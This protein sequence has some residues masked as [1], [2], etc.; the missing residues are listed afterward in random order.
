M[1]ISLRKKIT[2]AA[3]LDSLMA[4]ALLGSML[5][6][7]VMFNQVNHNRKIAKKLAAE[8]ITYARIYAKYMNDNYSTLRN[9]AQSGTNVV[10]SPSSISGKWSTDLA[11]SNL[12]RQ[13]PCVSIVA[14]KK[15]GY[16]ESILY[17]AGGNTTFSN[18]EA[19]ILRQ[20]LV[21]LGGA[22]G[23]FANGI[24]RGN[25]GWSIDRASDFLATSNQCGNGELANNSLAINMDLLPEWNRET[26][27]STAI[28]KEI[29]GGGSHDGIRKMP[30]HLLNANTSKSDVTL[31]SGNG[32]IVD[33]HDEKNPIK[34]KMG[35]AEGT[36]TATIGLYSNNQN[37]NTKTLADTLEPIQTGVAGDSCDIQEVGKIIADRGNSVTA[38]YL[39]RS[40]LVCSQNS[41]MCASVNLS[42]TCYLPTEANRIIFANSTKGIQSSSG[43]FVCPKET[44]FASSAITSSGP[45]IGVARLQGDLSG[46]TVTIGY[47]LTTPNTIILQVTCSNMPDYEINAMPH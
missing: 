15:T 18:K 16:L 11:T 2:G 40:T 29:D 12:F 34:L 8:T 3:V 23:L 10:L 20:A 39:N 33:N 7:W 26:M 46:Y 47:Y 6:C 35:Y 21:T 42:N 17:Y 41:M 44:P 32:V 43:N 4:L 45:D 28:A 38:E 30:G 19:L 14:N 22:G 37:T 5:T 36:N 25:S 31:L 27:P 13:T 9:T 1:K 24:I